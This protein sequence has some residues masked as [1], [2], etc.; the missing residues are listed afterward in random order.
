MKITHPKWWWT[1]IKAIYVTLKISIVTLIE[2][3]LKRFE[4]EVGDL[5]L[6]WWSQKLLEF[7]DMKYTVVN[8]NNFEFKANHPYIIMS[9]HSSHFDIPLLFMALKG[10]IRM[11]TKKELFK[12]PIWGKGM[13]VAEFVSIDRHNRIQAFKDLEV[14]KEKMNSGIM[15]W[16]APEGTRTRT[17]KLLPFKKGGFFLALETGATILPVGIRGT[18]N[19]WAAETTDVNEGVHVEVHLGTPIDTSMYTVQQRDQLAEVVATQIMEL[20]QVER[21]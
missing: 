17:G 5:R 3:K 12:I 6:R 9:N 16:V 11:M 20:A 18:R 15:I 14:A 2:V 19:V 1:W 21:A 7:V 13:L 8:P 4:R 10:S